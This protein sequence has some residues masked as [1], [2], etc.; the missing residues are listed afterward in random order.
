MITRAIFDQMI[1]DGVA[2]LDADSNFYLDEAPL[3]SNGK[4]AEGV[5]LIERAGSATPTV[6][7]NNQ[8]TVI[9]FYVGFKDKTKIDS[10]L[11]AILDWLASWNGRGICTISGSVDG[12]TTGEQYSV[13]NVRIWMTATPSNQGQTENGI[14]VK[15]ASAQVFYDEN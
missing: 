8:S 9:D 15:M 10:S 11:K 2:N 5:W 1:N 3:Q 7:R 6:R 12:T 14:I 4:P 13:S